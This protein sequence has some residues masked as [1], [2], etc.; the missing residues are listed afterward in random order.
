MFSKYI[1]TNAPFDIIYVDGSNIKFVEV[2]S[3]LSKPY[4]IYMSI[5]ELNFAYENKDHY[6][7]II[8]INNEIFTLERLPI[9]QIYNQVK[10]INSINSLLSISNFELSLEVD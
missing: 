2:N 5:G 7:L 3:C 8:V 9:E 4:K 10:E 6:E 1:H